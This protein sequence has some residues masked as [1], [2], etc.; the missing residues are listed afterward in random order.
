MGK[1]KQTNFDPR[2]SFY[3]PED[4]G[5]GDFSIVNANDGWHLYY[6]YREFGQENKLRPLASRGRD[7]KI[8]HAFSKDLSY[9]KT[10]KPVI[11]ID[12][13]RKFE[14]LMI[15][16][17][18][19]IKHNDERW[20]M[21]YTGVSE[22]RAQSTCVATSRD[23]FSWDKPLNHPIFNV[24]NNITLSDGVSKALSQAIHISDPDV[25]EADYE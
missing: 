6:L 4:G 17:P 10:E 5:I 14:N 8:G 3:A 19:V 13:N 16:A 2:Q 9:W 25:I 23:L 21:F 1:I 24:Q 22:D 20:Y 7:R 18:A 12:E 11:Y 15:W